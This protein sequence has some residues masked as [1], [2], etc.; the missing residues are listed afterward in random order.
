MFFSFFN[1]S[2]IISGSTGPIFTI[3]SS[4]ERYLRAFSRSGPLFPI[5]QGTLPLQPILGKICEMTFIQHAG[6]SQRIRISQF[7]LTGVKGHD[8]CYILYNFGEN[9]FTNHRDYARSFGTFWDETAKLDIII[10][11]N[12]S[13]NTGLN[14]TNFSALVSLYMRI[15]KLK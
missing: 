10:I 6:I 15:I 14:F 1:L 13:A 7:R 12:I 8:F 9:W 11:P 3:F 2:Q 5:P 4:N